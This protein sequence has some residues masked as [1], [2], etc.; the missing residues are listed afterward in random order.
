MPAARHHTVSAFLLDRFARD[1]DRGRRVCMLDKKTGKPTAVSP[2]D[3]AVRRH[4]YSLD[5]DGR[6]DP[7][8]EH[9]LSVIEGIAAKLVRSLDESEFPI[10]IDRLEL[11]LFVAVCWLRT[12][13]QREQMASLMEQVTAAMVSES[14]KLDP[15]AAQRAAAATDID[16][17]PEEVE[18]SRRD[19]VEGLDDGRYGVEIQKNAMIGYLLEGAQSSSWTMFLLDWTLVRAE[20]GS[21]FILGDNPVSLYDQ[22]PVFPGGGVGI[23]SSPN[24]QMFMPIGP[25]VGIL[26]EANTRVWSWARD[27]LEKLHAMTDEER[28]AAVDPH[29]GRW[30]EGIATP[31]FVQELNLR[32]YANAERFI[33]GSQKAVQ[34]IHAARTRHGV[35]LG[36]VTPRGPRLHMVEDDDR[37]PTGLRIT[38]TFKPEPRD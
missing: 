8:V 11:G 5:V 16:L 37:S 28:A 36:Q 9:V 23:L 14:F 30:G 34:D 21:E 29:E 17:T 35:R 4:F 15:A 2:R 13:T 6:R 25:S 1:T 27:N 19:L 10:G 38:R 32:S 3:A 31:E 12:P 22:M 26:L 33:F 20:E 18:A 24:T 7:A